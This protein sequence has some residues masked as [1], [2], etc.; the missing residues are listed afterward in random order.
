MIKLE[1]VLPMEEY[2]IVRKDFEDIALSPVE[3][4]RYIIPLSSKLIRKY[5]FCFRA[6]SIK[7]DKH[8]LT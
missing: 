5:A 3:T 7:K 1:L 2:G 4:S 6:K 8:C